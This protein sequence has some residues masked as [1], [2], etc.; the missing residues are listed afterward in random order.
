MD[1]QLFNQENVSWQLCPVS[2]PRDTLSV[3]QAKESFRL[4]IVLLSRLTTNIPNSSHSTQ[5][6][7]FEDKW[8]GDPRDQQMTKPKPKARHKNAQSRF[9]LVVSESEFGSFYVDK[10]YMPTTDQLADM[11][12]KGIFTKMQ[13]NSLLGLWHIRR[14]DESNDVR[15]FSRQHLSGSAS[16]KPQAMTQVTT[17]P[18]NVDQ[19]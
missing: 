18:E 19:K 7:L 15:S 8:R 1:H 3:T 13:W 12:T 4:T 16:G 5:H 11:L 2:Q 9:G 17:E 6:Y 14:P 10:K